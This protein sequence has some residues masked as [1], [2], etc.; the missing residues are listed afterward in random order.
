MRARVQCG[1]GLGVEILSLYKHS[2]LQEDYFAVATQQGVM[3]V[4]GFTSSRPVVIRL[5]HPNQI[6]EAFDSITYNKVDST[7]FAERGPRTSRL[8]P[9]T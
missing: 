2:F 4:D 8:P 9:E 6:T 7:F 5:T 3:T 1:L